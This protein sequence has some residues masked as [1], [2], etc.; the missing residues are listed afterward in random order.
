MIKIQFIRRH[1]HWKNLSGRRFDSRFD[2]RGV[3]PLSALLLLSLRAA[4]GMAGCRDLPLGGACNHDGCDDR[5]DVYMLM[6]EAMVLRCFRGGGA[7]IGS[8]A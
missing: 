7:I 5:F 1:V 8:S 2:E 6:I 3:L 4:P